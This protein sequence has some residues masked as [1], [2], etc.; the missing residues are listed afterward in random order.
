[1]KLP[2]VSLLSA[3]AL[4][5]VAASLAKADPVIFYDGDPNGGL[6]YDMH[7]YS[8]TGAYE[9]FRDWAYSDFTVP[10]GQTWTL[11][12]MF[13]NFANADPNAATI[14]PN[15]QYEIRTGMSGSNGGTLVDSDTGLSAAST[16]QGYQVGGWEAYGYS[17]NL[18]SPV[19]LPGGTTYWLALI[20]ISLNGYNVGLQTTSNANSVNS[21]NDQSSEFLTWDYLDP[22]DVYSSLP[23]DFSVGVRGTVAIVPEPASAA[24]LLVPALALLTRRRRAAQRFE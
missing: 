15:F 10:L 1:M 4:F 12:S 20:P 21:P 11:T 16:D 8:I 9:S 3:F 24:I 5:V 13:G 17:V 19:T 6:T 23:D 22:T 18:T 14:I 2:R 7:V